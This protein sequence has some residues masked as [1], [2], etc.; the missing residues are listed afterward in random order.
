M[1]QVAKRPPA[2]PDVPAPTGN[3]WL[4]TIASFVIIALVVAADAAWLVKEA[5]EGE[6]PPL[7]AA[8][9]LMMYFGPLAGILAGVRGRHLGRERGN[10]RAHWVATAGVVGSCLVFLPI[11]GVI[12]LL[13]SLLFG[14]G[15]VPIG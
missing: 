5:H 4:P 10:R 7:G 1:S 9:I 12:A 6:G 14:N 13:V 11:L 3:P 15:P 8:V 2:R